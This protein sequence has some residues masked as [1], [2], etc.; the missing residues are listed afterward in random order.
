MAGKPL[1]SIG[2]VLLLSATTWLWTPLVGLVVMIRH[3]LGGEEWLHLSVVLV[4]AMECGRTEKHYS[5][6]GILLNIY[7]Y[8]V[9]YIYYMVVWLDLSLSPNMA[10]KPCRS[11]DRVWSRCASGLL[12]HAVLWFSVWSPE[13]LSFS[14]FRLL[15]ENSIKRRCLVPEVGLKIKTCPGRTHTFLIAFCCFSFTYWWMNGWTCRQ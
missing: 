5:W 11:R 10:I 12:A 14:V 2:V 3:C 8:I 4:L 1:S 13:L 6:F 7:L 9:Y 15:L